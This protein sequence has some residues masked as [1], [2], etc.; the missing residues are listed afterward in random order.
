MSDEDEKTG[1]FKMSNA[2]D[3]FSDSYGAKNKAAAGLKLVG[4][5][6]FNVARYGFTEI[7]PALIVN[8]GKAVL[9]NGDLSNDKRRE[10]EEKI[11]RANDFKSRASDIKSAKD[12][13]KSSHSDED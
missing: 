12:F 2:V 5:G 10:I 13:V 3:D 7:I 4:K 11:D 1:Y 9:K 6:L 8:Q